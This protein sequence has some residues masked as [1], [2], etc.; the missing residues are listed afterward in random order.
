MYFCRAFAFALLCNGST[1][2]SGS[3]CMGSNPIGATKKTEFNCWI[4]F[5]FASLPRNL[6]I[7]CW[8]KAKAKSKKAKSKKCQ[9]NIDHH[10]S[11][12]H[13]RRIRLG[14]NLRSAKNRQPIPQTSRK[15]T[16][17]GRLL[18]RQRR[19]HT[20]RKRTNQFRSPLFY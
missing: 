16:V 18:S 2:D 10:V 4:R 5:F 11:T 15:R 13:C 14:K 17:A 12:R 3:V 9:T 19:S 1:A 7:G 6:A 20:G 8:P